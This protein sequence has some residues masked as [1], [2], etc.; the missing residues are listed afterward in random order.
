[1]VAKQRSLFWVKTN[2]TSPASS[3]TARRLADKTT[4][5]RLNPGTDP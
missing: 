4:I 5:C 3:S 1:M 2:I